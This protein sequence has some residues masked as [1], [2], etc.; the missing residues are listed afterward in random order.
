MSCS[1]GS[2]DCRRGHR[3]PLSA[4]RAAFRAQPLTGSH[5]AQPLTG[6][7]Q[8]RRL[9][10][11][12]QAGNQTRSARSTSRRPTD[13]PARR[14]PACRPQHGGKA[15]DFAADNAGHLRAPVAWQ[16]GIEL[17][18][19]WESVVGAVEPPAIVDEFAGCGISVRMAVQTLRCLKTKSIKYAGL[20]GLSGIDPVERLGLRACGLMIFRPESCLAMPVRAYGTGTIARP[21]TRLNRLPIK[22]QPPKQGRSTP[23]LVLHHPR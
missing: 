5:Q 9:T 6:S 16:W 20:K 23:R 14:C 19:D 4:L 2:R 13:R 17:R 12:H 15:A 8:A 7:H 1:E 21:E 3:R 22:R 10:G 11:S 18:P